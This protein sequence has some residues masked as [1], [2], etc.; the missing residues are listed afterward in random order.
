MFAGR[1]SRKPTSTFWK[2]FWKTSQ[3]HSPLQRNWRNTCHVYHSS[4][5]THVPPMSHGACTLDGSLQRRCPEC[6]GQQHGW[7]KWHGEGTVQTCWWNPQHPLSHSGS[8]AQD[9]AA[10]ESGVIRAHASY[11]ITRAGRTSKGRWAVMPSILV[12]VSYLMRF[13]SLEASSFSR[14]QR[15]CAEAVQGDTYFDVSCPISKLR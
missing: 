5:W 10:E 1:W 13:V 9:W 2:T 3:S 8:P 7:V 12:H 15:Y 4:G 11:V 14:A 6:S